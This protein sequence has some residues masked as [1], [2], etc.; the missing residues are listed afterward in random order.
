MRRQGSG[1]F[2]ARVDSNTSAKG[3]TAVPRGRPLLTVSQAAVL[4]GSDRSTL[5]KAIGENRFPLP[6]VRLNRQIL[7]PRAALERFIGGAV[8]YDAEE[9][10]SEGEDF[11]PTCGSP[12]ASSAPTPAS[13]RPT[14]LAA[15]RSSSGIAS[16]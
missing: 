7:I 12:L 13:I 2:R 14:C 4:L 6:V 15:R 10:M 5:Y 3:G 9:G 11:C 8:A 1:S 16:V